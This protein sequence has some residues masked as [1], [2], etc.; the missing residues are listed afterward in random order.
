MVR[1]RALLILALL[2]VPLVGP[3]MPAHAATI[4][5]SEVDEAIRLGVEAVYRAVRPVD[6]SF[7]KYVMPDH[8]SPTISIAYNGKLYVPGSFFD[9]G[10][11]IYKTELVKVSNNMVAWRYYFNIDDDDDYDVVIYAELTNI[12]YN[13]DRLYIYIDKAEYNI[14]VYVGAYSPYKYFNVGQ[15]WSTT[16]DINDWNKY[17]FHSARYVARHSTRIA[18]WLLE[19]EG[20]SYTASKLHNL[21]NGCGYTYD[22]YAPIFGR[23]TSYPDDFFTRDATWL[24]N[25]YSCLPWTLSKYS[26]FLNYPYKSR[27]YIFDAFSSYTYHAALRAWEEAP[28]ANLLKAMHLLDKYGASRASEAEQLI[29]QVIEDGKWDGYGIKYASIDAGYVASG[30]HTGPEIPYGYAGY[31]VY[32]NAA[33]LAALVK[34]YQVTGDR[35][36]AGNDILYMADRLAGILVKLQWKYEHKT[37]WGYVRLALF[38]GWWPAAYEIGSLISKSSAWG[39]IDTLTHTADNVAG[40]LAKVGIDFPSEALR[41]MPSEWPFAIVNSES[42]I[43]AIQALKLYRQLGRE[44]IDPISDVIAGFDGIFVESGGGGY[45]AIGGSHGGE[46]SD[47]GRWIVASAL[48]PGLSG[49]AWHYQYAKFKFNLESSGYYKLRIASMVSYNGKD[50]YGSSAYVYLVVKLLNAYGN[51]V[52]QV[53]KLVDHVDEN[54]LFNK[55][56]AVTVELDTGYLTSGTYYVEIGLK[57]VADN[58]PISWEG[59]WINGKVVNDEIVIAQ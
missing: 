20:A 13:I 9:P 38:R 40:I 33:L 25:G 31:P 5:I 1:I 30:Y 35:W 52:A 54:T 39:I 15:G 2:L 43:L 16:I 18:A 46:T 37:P 24:G 6:T 11:S 57:V 41:P 17:K 27:M 51:V 50:S 44:P 8:P 53:E 19:D 22:V 55:A 36:I 59:V 26:Y 32:L 4:P 49:D 47:D 28:L 7:S 14:D 12:D 29:A 58:S 3:V 56:K 48:V 23:S 10:D 45:A 21:M 42:T 34:Y